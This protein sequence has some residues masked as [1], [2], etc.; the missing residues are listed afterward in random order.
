MLA[1]KQISFLMSAGD[2]VHD[3]LKHR[4]VDPAPDLGEALT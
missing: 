3:Y 1:V 2:R 4:L